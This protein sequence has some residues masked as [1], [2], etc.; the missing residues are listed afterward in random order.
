MRVISP[1]VAVVFVVAGALLFGSLAVGPLLAVGDAGHAAG[2]AGA[3]PGRG[4]GSLINIQTETSPLANPMNCQ[5]GNHTIVVAPNTGDMRSPLLQDYNTLGAEGGGTLELGAGVYQLNETL[6]LQSYS[7]VTIQGSGIGNTVLSLPPSPIG[8]FAADNG[9]LVGVYNTSMGGPVGGVS[10]NLIQLS[11]PNPINNFALCDLTINAQANNAS[12]AWS[13]SLVFDGSGG[14]N[15]RYSNIAEVGFFGP[16]TTP[17]GLHLESSSQDK[18][19]GVGYSVDHLFAVNNTLPFENYSGYR[20]GPNFLN[21]G[22]VLNCT[23][24]H[25]TGIGQAAFEVAPP[26]G[27]LI[28]NWN[29]SGH[30]TIDPATGGTWGNTLFQNVTVNTNGTAA[31][32]A[33]SSSVPDG[34]GGYDSN[35]TALR[36]NNDHFYGTVVGGANLVDVE[37][38]TFQGEINTTPAVFEGNSVTWAQVSSQKLSLPIAVEGAPVR[39][40]SSV[41]RGNTFVF[42]NGTGKQN[43]LFQLT[44]PQNAWSNDTVEL[45]G[46]TSGYLLSA[47]GISITQNSSFTNI[48]YDPLGNRS[49][50]NLVF[51]DM[52]NSPGFQDLGAKVGPLIQVTNDLPLYIPAEP[53][54]LVGTAKSP[55]QVA[56]SWNASSG[57]VTNYTV[58]VGDSASSLIPKASVGLKTNYMVGGLTSGKKHFFGI[59]AWNSSYRS[60]VT[61]PIEVATPGYAPS[62]PN[63][64]AVK[65]LAI[66]E[67]GIQWNPSTGTVTNYTIWD[68]TN[69]SI[70]TSGFSTGDVANFTVIGLAP[71]TTYYFAVQ[72]WNGSWGS[73]RSASVNAT[74]LSDVIPPQAPGVPNGLAVANVGSFAVGI[75]WNPS[76]GNVTN[77][78]LLTGRNA[79][80]VSSHFSVGV[81]TNFTVTDLEPATT[82]YFAVQAWNGSATSGPCTPV[83]VT[84]LAVNVTAHAPGVPSRLGVTAVGSSQVGIRWNPST[85]VVTNYT[86]YAGT[87]VSMM[88]SHYSVGDVTNFTVT[89]LEPATTYFFAVQAWNGSWASVPCAPVSATSSSTGVPPGGGP[90]TRGSSETGPKSTLDW[91]LLF[92][93]I[94]GTLGV[95]V[96]PLAF[97]GRARMISRLRPRGPPHMGRAS[98]THRS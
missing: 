39:G 32:T 52:A 17:N 92:G 24:D 46:P 40:M 56:I 41:L 47:P 27:C 82:Y 14:T 4:V 88:S 2:A 83:E 48:I 55:T 9:S 18:Y 86:V 80:I 31:T 96:L 69:A 1:R 64:L 94:G 63:G 20:G 78:T 23:I 38:S 85:G 72:A 22:A 15:H 21:V 51:V 62:V 26:R 25:V 49:P 91:I 81:V 53:T 35:F 89:G 61:L 68:G 43:D 6:N 75:H 42:P 90:P 11:G 37:N 45:A 19:P 71:D 57:P 7:N 36:W 16:S 13:G 12:E 34:S 95:V 44:V 70:L 66:T 77:Y 58:L 60:A 10:A 84:T 97:M 59:E 73:G 29:I 8:R 54:G 87:N 30:I 5:Q 67:A 65:N 93:T 3:L 76:T 98:T 50:A 74:T 79:S 33:L 28:E